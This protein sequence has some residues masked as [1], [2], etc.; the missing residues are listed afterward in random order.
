METRNNS[1]GWIALSAGIVISAFLLSGAL[2]KRTTAQEVI[3]VAGLGTKDFIS[4]LIVWNGSFTKKNAELKSAYDALNVDREKIKK[5]FLEKGIAANQIVFSA[6]NISK[7]YETSGDYD[8]K[9]QVFVGYNLSQ[10]VRIESKEVD[11]VEAVSREVSEL[12]NNGIEFESSSP[13]YFYTQLPTLKLDLIAKATEDAK[14]RAE[15]IAE[16]AGSDIGNLKSAN[17]GIIQITGQNSTEE[18]EWGGTFNT[19]SKAKTASITVRL[20]YKID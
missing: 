16:K 20:E 15:K 8:N 18:Y 7:D 17:T 2:K 6:V 11:K 14:Q 19:T 5:Y 13:S 9:R 4:D 3:S 12:I 1:L 10:N